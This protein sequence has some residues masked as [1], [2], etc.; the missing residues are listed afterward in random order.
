MRTLNK[1]KIRMKYSLYV[2]DVVIF[3]RDKDGNIKYVSVGGKEV[4]VETG[5]TSDGYSE[6]VEFL[7]NITQSGGEKEAAEYGLDIAS[8]NA[9]LIVSKGLLPIDEN[10]LIFRESE[11]KT[12]K[13]TGMIKKESADYQVVAVKKSLNVDR[14]AL[15]AIVK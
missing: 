3:E 7:G 6:A 12:D 15:K 4:P 14:Y 11:P 13:R 9:V 8:Y 1:N 10:S 5:E 2:E